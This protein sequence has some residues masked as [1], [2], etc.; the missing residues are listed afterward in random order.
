[1]EETNN[2]YQEINITGLW[3][4]NLFDSLEKLQ[5]FERICREG[6][7]SLMEYL[8]IPESKRAEVQF[9]NL[10]MM[11]TETG[12]LLV[13]AKAKLD[14]TF[15]LQ[16]QLKIRQMKEL[17][18]L[19]H[20]KIFI[21]FINQQSGTMVHNL[22][23]GYFKILMELTQIRGEIVKELSDILYGKGEEKVSSMDKNR[24]MTDDT[25]W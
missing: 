24:P 3:L 2:Q 22:S 20:D 23:E 18:D 21:P 16:S 11:I 9:Q 4:K 1:M 6:A 14:K 13:N 19:N 25:K 10:K 17:V 7:L 5:D 8:Q 12:I 15:Y